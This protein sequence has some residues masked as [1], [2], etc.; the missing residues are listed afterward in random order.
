MI[1]LGK[2]FEPSHGEKRVLD[3]LKAG[4]KV[5]VVGLVKPVVYEHVQA[6][7][8]LRVFVGARIGTPPKVDMV[9][10]LEKPLHERPVAFPR[11][12]GGFVLG[13]GS[14]QADRTLFV[15]KAELKGLLAQ[16]LVVKPSMIKP[17][18]VLG[19]V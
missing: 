8:G 5:H 19:K 1:N 11:S 7:G 12:G 16:K 18:V 17:H 3:H 10:L 13:E 4:G 9:R 6:P 14:V 2:P 15:K